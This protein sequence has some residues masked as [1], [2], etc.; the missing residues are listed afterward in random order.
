MV[1]KNTGP[2]LIEMPLLVSPNGCSGNKII[3]K[4]M[5]PQP[6][7]IGILPIKIA[8]PEGTNLEKKNSVIT[9]MARPTVPQ[10]I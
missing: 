3:C 7:H 9:N 6:G 2:L 4:E 1:H 8:V 10:Q 5:I